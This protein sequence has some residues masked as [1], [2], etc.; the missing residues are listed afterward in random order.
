MIVVEVYMIPQG[1]HSEKHLI[2]SA[3]INCIGQHR[4]DGDRAYVARL[5]KDP[6][7]GGPKDSAELAEVTEALSQGQEPA[8]R[9]VYKSTRIR[10][11]K[12]GPRGVWD[13]IGGIL[14]VLMGSRLKPYRK[15]EAE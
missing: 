10:G 4:E 3:I 12:P 7:F 5:M 2:S 6:E 13:L 1:D 8:K 14:K 11:H 15:P 9:R